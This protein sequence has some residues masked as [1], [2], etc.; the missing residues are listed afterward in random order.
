M[1]APLT[2]DR[3]LYIQNRFSALLNLCKRYTNSK[4]LWIIFNLHI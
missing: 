4:S 1:N 2:H 3:E